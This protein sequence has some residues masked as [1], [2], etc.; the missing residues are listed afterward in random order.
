MT[1]QH[2]L[3]LAFILSPSACGES[4]AAVIWWNVPFH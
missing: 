3:I 4:S 1:L 2:C